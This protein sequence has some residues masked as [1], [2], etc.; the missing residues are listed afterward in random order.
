MFIKWLEIDL[1]SWF[2]ILLHTAILTICQ[3]KKLHWKRSRIFVHLF[4]KKL[5]GKLQVMEYFEGVWAKRWKLLFVVITLKEQIKLMQEDV[6]ILHLTNPNVHLQFLIFKSFTSSA[7]IIIIDF[8]AKNDKII[9]RI[10]KKN[11]D[12]ISFLKSIKN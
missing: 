3:V 1:Q 10:L 7:V 2:R 9:K 6:D 5:T 8:K 12:E 11:S 4:T